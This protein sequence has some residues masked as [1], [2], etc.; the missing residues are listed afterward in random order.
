MYSDILNGAL[1]GLAENG[2]YVE[3]R[4]SENLSR[5]YDENSKA[6][7]IAAFKGKSN[8]L[9]IVTNRA[10]ILGFFRDDGIFDK[11]RILISTGDDSLKWANNAFGYFKKN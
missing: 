5:I 10:M 1:N 4:V 11:N 3:L 9:L 2:N 8:F 7:Y 6:K